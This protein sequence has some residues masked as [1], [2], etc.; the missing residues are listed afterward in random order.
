MDAQLDHDWL[1]GDPSWWDLENQLPPDIRNGELMPNDNWRY[2]TPRL[3]NFGWMRQRMKP[4]AHSL[5]LP[6]AWSPF[7]LILTIIPLIFPGKT[8]DDQSLAFIFFF[9]SWFLV[10]YP[11]FN[12][13]ELQLSHIGGFFTL[14]VDWKLLLLGIF[15]FPVHIFIDPMFGWLSYAFFCAAMIRTFGL[16]Q[17]MMNIPP[18]RFIIPIDKKNWNSDNLSNDWNINSNKW[19][20]GLIASSKCAGGYLTLSGIC[21]SKYNFLSITFVH[22]SG[23]VQDPFFTTHERQET[24]E[25]LLLNPPPIT[26]IQWPEIFLSPLEEE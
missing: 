4:L 2:T 6:L 14:P 16:I 18:S 7:F 5:L 13:R 22:K 15:I 24:L 20:I 21:R 12:S 1:L 17:D 26:G 25:D 9:L 3:G 8:P 10:Y 19:K 11:L 23:F